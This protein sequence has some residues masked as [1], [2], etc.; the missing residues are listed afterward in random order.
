MNATK[1]INKPNE[2]C[3]SSINEKDYNCQKNT[4]ISLFCG[5]SIYNHANY[6]TFY[7]NHKRII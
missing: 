6:E 2:N 4:D 7:Y 3:K 5:K 1:A